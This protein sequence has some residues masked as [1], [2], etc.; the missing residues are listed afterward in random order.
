MKAFHLPSVL[1]SLILLTSSPEI[2]AFNAESL[3]FLP[4]LV[5]IPANW[6]WS[7]KSR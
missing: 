7:E 5:W 4:V 1:L 2:A 3:V 6:M